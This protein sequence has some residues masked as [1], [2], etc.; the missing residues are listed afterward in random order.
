MVATYAAEK[1]MQG[2]KVDTI[3]L[4]AK[5]RT[6]AG[7]FLPLFSNLYQSHMEKMVQYLTQ[8]K[9]IVQLDNG[10][11]RGIDQVAKGVEYLHTGK[12][13]G[14]VVVPLVQNDAKI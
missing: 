2:D 10:G 4:L 6:V 14:K 12:N 13:K 9:L 8:G 1:G 5:S 7:F 11:L 3:Q